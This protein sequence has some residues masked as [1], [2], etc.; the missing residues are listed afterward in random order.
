MAV[1]NSPIP[2]PA[3]ASN[4]AGTDG[5]TYGR[6]DR[7]PRCG[8][9]PRTLPQPVHRLPEKNDDRDGEQEGEGV[10]GARERE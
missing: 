9:D 1:V 2:H 6:T 3:P 10:V 5:W 7:R 8:M 4:P